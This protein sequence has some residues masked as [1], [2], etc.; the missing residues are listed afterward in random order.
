MDRG[1]TQ[2]CDLID[3]AQFFEHFRAD[4]SGKNFAAA[5]LQVMHDFIDELFERQQAGRSFLESFRDAA[6]EFAALKRLVGAIAFHDSQIGALDFFVSGEAISAAETLAPAPN[7]GAIPRLA[8]VDDLV[9][10][11]AALGATH[12]VSEVSITLGVVASMHLYA[13]ALCA[14]GFFAFGSRLANSKPTF[15]FSSFKCAENGRPFLETNLGSKSVLPVVISFCTCSFGISRCKI[16]LLMR[17]VHVFG[18]AIAFSQ[19]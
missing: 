18:D 9:I 8:R 15:P 5:G 13:A 11:R 12:S 6:G 14:A 19:A 16:F 4:V 3:A 1:V 2:I 7:A 10:P 17:N